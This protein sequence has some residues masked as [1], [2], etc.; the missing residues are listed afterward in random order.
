MR[1]ILIKRTI[2]KDRDARPGC[3]P[4]GRFVLDCARGKEA[5]EGVGKARYK[6]WTT[7][8][9]MAKLHEYVKQGMSDYAIAKELNID[10]SQLCAWKRTHPEIAAAL[11]RDTGTDGGTGVTTAYAAPRVLNDVEKVQ[12]KIDRWIAD[13][14]ANDKPLTKTGLAL[15]LG[16]SK[17]TLYR[18]ERENDRRNA[19]LVI[20]TNTGEEHLLSVSDLIKRAVL[21]IE[22]DLNERAI[23]RGSVGA[24]FALKNW[25]GYADKKDIGVSQGTTAQAA[26]RALTSAQIDERIQALLE[27][28]K[29]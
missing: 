18:L 21:A 26:E 2:S 3:A 6:E 15:A 12:I 5:E 7:P 22:E 19:Q 28:S 1:C 27:K 29:Q 25:Y 23:C 9:G 17:D 20:D 11:A 4:G 14:R 24:I 8:E 13:R 16:I 10:R